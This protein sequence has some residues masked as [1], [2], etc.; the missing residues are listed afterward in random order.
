MSI[1]N[2]ARFIPYIVLWNFLL[3]GIDWVSVGGAVTIRNRTYY[4]GKSQHTDEGNNTD[5]P[6]GDNESNYPYRKIGYCPDPNKNNEADDPVA[7]GSGGMSINRPII[8]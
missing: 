8:V 7:Y 1:C 3:S 5:N 2:L 6:V 4:S